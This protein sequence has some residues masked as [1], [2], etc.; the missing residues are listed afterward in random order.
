MKE[1]R[2]DDE[3]L[4]ALLAGRLEGPERDELLAHLST[5]EDDADVVINAAAILREMEEED[6]RAEAGGQAEAPPVRET[7]PPSLRPNW[8][9]KAPRWIATAVLV[10]LVVLGFQMSRGR[11]GLSADP[12]QMAVRM[13]N[14]RQG[15]PPGWESNTP[16]DRPRGDAAQNAAQAGVFLVRLAVAVQARDAVATA[17]LADQTQRRFDPQGGQALR[18][19]AA[20]AGQPPEALQPLLEQAAARLEALHE[21]ERDHLRLGAWTEAARLAAAWRDD[22]FFRS[23]DTRRALGLAERLTREDPAAQAA[24]A[25]VR[26]ALPADAPP[27]WDALATNLDA[28]LRAIAS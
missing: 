13:D 10:G 8:R 28:L 27:A 2:Y 5:A 23:G 17:R 15:L 21:D 25:G 7:L 9:R 1:P 6:A 19:V 18:D 16:W 24:V 3:R 26:T 11:G 12:V 14:A 4:A 22:A 20:R